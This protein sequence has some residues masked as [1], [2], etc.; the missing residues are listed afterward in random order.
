MPLRRAI[1]DGFICLSLV[2]LLLL[3]IWAQLL[4][5][6]VNRANLYYMEQAPHWVHYPAVL[7]VLFVVSG[8][9]C[10][11]AAWARRSSWGGAVHLARGALLLLFLAALNSLRSQ[12]PAEMQE[13]IAA[14]LGTGGAI[15]LGI[16]VVGL[17]LWIVRK[18]AGRLFGAIEVFAIFASPFVLMTVGQTLWAWSRYESTSFA[19]SSLEDR[20]PARRLPPRREGGRVVWIIFDELDQRVAYGV[21]P[22]VADLPELDRLRRESFFAQNAYAPAGETRRSIASML[23]GRQIGWAMPDG[24]ATLPCALEGAPPSEEVRDCWS[25]YPNVFQETRALGAN[26]GIAGWYHPYCRIF[27]ES[28]S[29]C[30]WAGLPYWNSPRFVD[31]LSQ[32]WQEVLAPIPILGVSAGPGARVRRAHRDAF[33]T[34]REAGLRI[35]TDP[36]IGLALLHFPVPHHPDIYDPESGELSIEDERS[37]VDNLL[38]ADRVLGEVRAGMQRAA[39]WE[40]STVIVTS[41]HWWRAIHRGDWGLTSEEEGLYADGVNRRIPFLV[42]FAGEAEALAYRK[43]FNTLLL[44]DVILEILAERVTTSDALG[45][46]L[47]ENRTRAPIPYPVRRPIAPGAAAG[48]SPRS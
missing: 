46:W 7:L 14:A 2:N 25:E 43:P 20:E 9:A 44:H 27:S 12:L 42:K 40:P 35:A 33:V 11:G 6:V 18:H 21:G 10:V 17:L 30:T 22:E 31:S 29:D 19:G 37:Y 23:L 16:L 4:P 8:T 45:A 26:V 28:V 38:L 1:F 36:G 48:R 15:C 39:L 24:P 47:D 34:I 32:Q 41:D 5:A 3:R 13:A